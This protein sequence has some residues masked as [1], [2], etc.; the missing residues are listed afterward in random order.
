MDYTQPGFWIAIATG[1]I[2]VGTL[3]TLQQFQTKEKDESIKLR[4][5]L[6]DIIIGA[7]LTSLIYMFIPESIENLISQGQEV[8]S[9]ATSGTSSISS[10]TKPE[11]EL[12]T[13]PARF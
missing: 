5:V 13:G 11:L 6:R 7:F 2:V 1:G 12:R 9:K 8:I 10:L 3:G 4:A